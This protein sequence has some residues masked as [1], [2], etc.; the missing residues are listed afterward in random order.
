MAGQFHIDVTFEMRTVLYRS[1]LS[2]D[3]MK[4]SDRVFISK[5]ECGEESR[6]TERQRERERERESV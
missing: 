5:R 6:I 3:K 2:I 4:M 1:S